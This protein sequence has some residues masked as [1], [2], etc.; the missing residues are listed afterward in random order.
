MR[1]ASTLFQ[2]LG[3]TFGFLATHAWGKGLEELAEKNPETAP[4]EP[5]EAE[6]SAPG[7]KDEGVEGKTGDEAAPKAPSAASNAIKGKAFIFTSIGWVRAGQSGGDWSSNGYSDLGFGYQILTFS[8]SLKLSATYR[9]NPI[10][11]TGTLNDHSYRGV[12]ETHNFGGL[13]RLGLPNRLSTVASCELGYLRS[14]LSPTDGLPAESSAVKHGV[15]L[16]LGGGGDY[17]VSES[18]EFT[19]GPRLYVGFGAAKIMQFGLTAG[20]GF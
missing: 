7:E 18:G 1:K 16:T 8:E 20:F 3:L 15:A 14:H 19:I 2:A 9:Y 12:W 17:K 10:A 5:E 6:A 4:P 11:V 13:L